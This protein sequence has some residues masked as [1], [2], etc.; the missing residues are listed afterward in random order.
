MGGAF[1]RTENSHSTKLLVSR[2]LRS[3]V[4]CRPSPT[5]PPL[6]IL[7]PALSFF[8][9]A[10]RTLLNRSS[11]FEGNCDAG[12]W[13]DRASCFDRR[14]LNYTR[15][16]EYKESSSGETY[17]GKL[18]LLCRVGMLHNK[19][20]EGLPHAMTPAILGHLVELVIGDVEAVLGLIVK[21]H[22]LL[23]PYSICI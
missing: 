15:R 12:L 17:E 7:R 23:G 18:Q 5:L 4:L 1:L 10:V 16:G 6:P 13:N 14:V 21:S 9:F 11:I 20:T 2:K 22:P 3:P 19:L 8:F